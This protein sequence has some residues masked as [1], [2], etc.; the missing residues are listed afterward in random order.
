MQ[1]DPHIVVPAADASAP[2]KS[3]ATSLPR[4]WLEGGSAVL[5][6]SYFD[7]ILANGM[8]PEQAATLL[9]TLISYSGD[10]APDSPYGAA[11]FRFIRPGG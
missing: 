4:C 10:V 8:S 11:G 6:F 2:G 1:V 3:Q 7:M 5:E 9:P